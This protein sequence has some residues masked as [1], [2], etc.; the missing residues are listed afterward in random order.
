MSSQTPDL[1]SREMSGNEVAF[2]HVPFKQ[3]R[4]DCSALS[5]AINERFKFL[6]LDVRGQLDDVLNLPR[7]H[8]L[9]AEVSL[10]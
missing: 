5:S 6:F 9:F 10:R 8:V 1:I 2:G 3:A 4:A 7:C